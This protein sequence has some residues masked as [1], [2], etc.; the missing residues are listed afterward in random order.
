[1][2]DS[3][4]LDIKT[5]D[6]VSLCVSVVGGDFTIISVQLHCYISGWRQV[7]VFMSESVSRLFNHFTQKSG[8]IQKQTIL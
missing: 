4:L 3:S 6:N 1:M 2:H 7:T 8:F 5:G